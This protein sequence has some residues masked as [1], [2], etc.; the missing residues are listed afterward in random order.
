MKKYIA[1]VAN[2]GF[3]VFDDLDRLLEGL[4]FMYHP[5]KEYFE[6]KWDAQ[7]YCIDTYNDRQKCYF[8]M[9]S[10]ASVDYFRTNW[11]YRRSDIRKLN[12]RE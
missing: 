5:K 9:F 8:D 7:S 12:G 4:R 10:E 1:V 2:D 6:S 3:G 11:F